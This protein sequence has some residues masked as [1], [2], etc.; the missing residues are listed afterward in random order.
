MARI[1]YVNGRYLPR[2][3]AAVNIEDRGYQF[4][5]G[6][7]EVCEVRG[8]KLVDERRHMERLTRSLGELRI[9]LPMPLN[10]LS[11]VLHE[12][13]RRN[14]IDYGTVYLQITRGV[15][16]RDHPFPP[17]GTKP[18]IVVTA[19]RLDFAKN[20]AMAADGVAVIS[21]PDN[22]WG[23]ADIKSISLLPNVL[24]KQAARE[25]GAREAWFIDAQGRVT[26]GSS[27][28]AW[29]VTAGGKVITM[30]PHN[31]AQSGLV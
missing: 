13:V 30:K 7:Y 8:G 12:T 15:A 9:A 14:R 21:L 16:R 20:E 27:S 3:D 26:E 29:I 23:R 25:Q 18:S 24:A 10:A 4:A 31:R 2:R 22:R 19:S 1:A 6:V 5:D 17:A 11:A 28:N